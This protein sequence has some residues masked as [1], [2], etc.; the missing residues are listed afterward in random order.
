MSL[1]E[2]LDQLFFGPALQFVAHSKYSLDE[3]VARLRAALLPKFWRLV[4]PFRTGL[5]GTVEPDRVHVKAHQGWRR[6][7]VAWFDGAFST[8]RSGVTLSGQIAVPL[9]YKL[10]FLVPIPI[11]VVEIAWAAHRGARIP[12]W[13]ITIATAV[14]VQ[15]IVVVASR[16]QRGCDERLIADLLDNALA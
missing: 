4:L 10:L 16:L 11:I 6:S 9:F 14:F 15:V 1:L 5:C 12:A 7:G 2:Y 3:S 13:W 8:D